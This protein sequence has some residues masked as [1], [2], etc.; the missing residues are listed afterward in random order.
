MII[1]GSMFS[2]LKA[3]LDPIVEKVRTSP[4]TDYIKD[5]FS[6]ANKKARSF[7][8]QRVGGGGGGGDGSP[9]GHEYK[10][11]NSEKIEQQS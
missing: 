6:V 10:Y 7:I 3:R 11:G 9:L 8:S 4:T 5:K 1:S 2:Y